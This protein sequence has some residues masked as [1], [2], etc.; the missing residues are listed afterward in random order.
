M[1]KAKSC[2]RGRFPRALA[3]IGLN[4]IAHT[5][6]PDAIRTPKFERARQFVL[7]D[8][9]PLLP[10]KFVSDT[11]FPAELQALAPQRHLIAV[12]VRRILGTERVSVLLRLYG[13][14]VHEVMLTTTSCVRTAV[15]PVWVSVDY[16]NHIIYRL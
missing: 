13:G 14:P 9:S 15:E 6:G 3:K 16:V 12:K 4:V 7:T 8:A 11:R 10:M 2:Q 1:P 5:S